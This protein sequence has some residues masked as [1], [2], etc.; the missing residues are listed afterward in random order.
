M[1]RTSLWTTN[2]AGK[3]TGTMMRPM[4]GILHCHRKE[5]THVMDRNIQLCLA[6]TTASN[7]HFSLCVSAS[8]PLRTGSVTFFQYLRHSLN[9]PSQWGEFRITRHEQWATQ[10][11]EGLIPQQTNYEKFLFP[12]A[13]PICDQKTQILNKHLFLIK[14]ERYPACCDICSQEKNEEV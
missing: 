10:I 4:G 13:F 5:D 2:H 6:S 14:R 12:E 7:K 3:S 11:L 8:C 9:V 1:K